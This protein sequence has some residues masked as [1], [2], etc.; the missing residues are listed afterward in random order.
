MILQNWSSESFAGKITVITGASRGIGKSIAD[1]FIPR[2]LL[3]I[4]WKKKGRASLIN[5]TRSK[6]S[7]N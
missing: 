7:I 2:W 3:V 1:R 6:S 4:F 5:T